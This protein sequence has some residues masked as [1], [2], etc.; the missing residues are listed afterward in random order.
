MAQLQWIRFRSGREKQVNSALAFDQSLQ[1]QQGFVP[2]D[3]PGGNSLTPEQSGTIAEKKSAAHAGSKPTG[4][5]DNLKSAFP[6][7]IQYLQKSLSG[8]D[9][10]DIA[11][12]EGD[13]WKRV[14]KLISE[15]K[16][17]IIAAAEGG[18]PLEELSAAYGITTEQV[19][20]IVNT[21]A[22]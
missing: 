7:D 3:G 8:I 17:K 15:V 6:K 5:T 13:H 18:K 9:D 4:D 16:D 12:A 11:R 19:E 10:K 20:G 21:K 2:I 1:K 14:G 22:Q